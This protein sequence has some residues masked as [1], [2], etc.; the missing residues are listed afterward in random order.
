MTDLHPSTRALADFMRGDSPP[1]ESRWIIRHL[2]DECPR[3]QEIAGAG[4]NQIVE[5]LGAAL[6]EAARAHD[7]RLLKSDLDLLHREP[8]T[9]KAWQRRRARQE[10]VWRLAFDWAQRE[11][12]GQAAY[13]SM[14]TI[15]SPWLISPRRFTT[16]SELTRTKN[17]WPRATV[18]SR[19]WTADRS[20][21]RSSKRA[22]K[23][24]SRRCGDG[25]PV[26]LNLR[27]GFG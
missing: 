17:S 6:S 24:H 19:L 25:F 2:L 9:A 12:T 22:R 8:V 10:Q 1:D 5:G 16:R 27:T 21:R 15:P 3:C 14:P 26:G 20:L 7:L 23:R 13:R 18:L 4:W 11:I